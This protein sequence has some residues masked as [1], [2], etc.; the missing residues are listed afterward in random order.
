MPIWLHFY[1]IFHITVA[2]LRSCPYGLQYLKYLQSGP[3]QKKIAS[4][5]LNY[6]SVI[7]SHNISLLRDRHIMYRVLKYKMEYE[8]HRDTKK[9]EHCY[10]IFLRHS[11][12][13]CALWGV[14]CGWGCSDF[15]VI[16][17]LY[18]SKKWKQE[19]HR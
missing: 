17:L 16:K 15:L 4:P 2:E 9:M 18:F 12:D 3:L 14:H 6:Y 19:Q 11:G 7:I 13:V 1:N 10:C 5:C 8:L